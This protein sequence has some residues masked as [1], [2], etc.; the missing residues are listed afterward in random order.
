MI[1]YYALYL[2]L[3]VFTIKMNLKKIMTVQN[4]N[5]I[6]TYEILLC[7]IVGQIRKVKHITYYYWIS[8]PF[9]P[10]ELYFQIWFD[11]LVGKF[12]NPLCPRGTGNRNVE[13][14]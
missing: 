2:P 14:F 3:E 1:S 9:L 7:F 10:E 13:L 11:F 12:N 6:V 5:N 8:T 4:I